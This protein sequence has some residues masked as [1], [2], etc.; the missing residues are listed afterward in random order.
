[1][2]TM[3]LERPALEVRNGHYNY[4]A[5]PYFDRTLSLLQER[6]PEI[7]KAFGQHWHWGYWDNPSSA[8][9]TVEDYARASERMSERMLE[10]AQAGDGLRLLDIGCGFGGTIACANRQH[11]R[12]KL[13]GLNID[14]RQLEIARDN[15][16]AK[17]ENQI[18]FIE[19]D[20]CSQPFA[21]ASFD[22]I[23]AVECVFHFPS[24]VRFFAEARRVLAPHGLL[25]LSDFVFWG[26]AWIFTPLWL[27][28][29]LAKPRRRRIWGEI[30]RGTFLQSTQSFYRLLAARH[31]FTLLE[32]RDITPNVLPTDPILIRLS[33]RFHTE[34]VEEVK[35]MDGLMKLKVIRYKI[36][37][38]QK[39]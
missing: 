9:S 10:A 25:A 21:D 20:A 28:H 32:T 26:A 37:V 39:V 19:G 8:G 12:M 30:N 5:M 18:E 17:G 15:V 29:F 13:T 35:A 22:R 11:Q 2:D 7:Q 14:P 1:M 36:L 4:N 31:G 24:R 27:L 16:M 34:M 23:T 38:F 6:D 33:E 3:R